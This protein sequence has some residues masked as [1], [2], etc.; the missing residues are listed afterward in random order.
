MRGGAAH[1]TPQRGSRPVLPRGTA[2]V[3]VPWG[4][5]EPAFVETTRSIHPQ[6]RYS[7][8]LF[9]GSA[10]V[11]A[12]PEPSVAVSRARNGQT[13]IPDDEVPAG[14]IDLQ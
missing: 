11:R 4:G 3:L 8:Q 14:P 9:M 2:P 7:T 1:G 6:Q 12:I 13:R 10:A 5:H